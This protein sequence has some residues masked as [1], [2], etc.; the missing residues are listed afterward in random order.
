MLM[1]AQERV[2]NVVADNAALAEKLRVLEAAQEK[3]E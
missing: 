1:A 3:K 2:L